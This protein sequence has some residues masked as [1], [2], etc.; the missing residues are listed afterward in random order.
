[1]ENIY[2]IDI[3]TPIYG[4]SIVYIYHIY[5]ADA[6]ELSPNSLPGRA[7]LREGCKIHYYLSNSG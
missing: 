1:M 2:S 7:L 6:I 4:V 3:C 5:G